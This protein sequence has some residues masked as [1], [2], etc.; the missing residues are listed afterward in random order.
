M[1]YNDSYDLL[2]K[3]SNIIN[4]QKCICIQFLSLIKH[5]Y[6]KCNMLF[7]LIVLRVEDF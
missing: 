4:D 5:A 1:H 2:S 3:E 7:Y 6:C